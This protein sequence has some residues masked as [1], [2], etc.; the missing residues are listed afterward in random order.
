[1]RAPA[2]HGG[3][4]HLEVGPGDPLGLAAVVRRL[5]DGHVARAPARQAPD[6]KPV[7]Q[8]EP[9]IGAHRGHRALDLARVHAG[10]GEGALALAHRDRDAGKK[11]VPLRVR[12]EDARW[13]RR[14]RCARCRRPPAPRRRSRPPSPGPRPQGPGDRLRPQL[15]KMERAA[16]Q[17][18]VAREVARG[19]AAEGQRTA[20]RC[21]HPCAASRPPAPGPIRG[22]SD[23]GA[24]G[25]GPFGAPSARATEVS[26][27]ATHFPSSACARSTRWP[28]TVTCAPVSGVCRAGR[29]PRPSRGSP[30]SVRSARAT[31]SGAGPRSRSCPSPR[32]RRS[33]RP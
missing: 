22:D 19:R 31:S 18:L 10:L 33:A 29:R 13:S 28:P 27:S 24:S 25:S 2:A 12:A 26:A 5:D 11:P 9:R 1:M 23:P 6:R 20:C 3:K 21:R 15:R 14:R 7:V 17:Q 4:A 16:Q 30:R 8:A 32:R